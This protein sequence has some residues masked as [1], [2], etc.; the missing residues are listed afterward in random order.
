MS[1]L[2]TRRALVGGL[3]A[4]G[5][6]LTG[7]GRLDGNSPFRQAL[8]A[9]DGFTLHA[10]RLILSERSLV[11]E[12]PVSQI[13]K[14][15]PMNGTAMP[16]GGYYQRILDT[17]F[18]DWKLRVHGLVDRPLSLT[19]AELQLLPARTQVTLHQCDEGWSAVAQWTGVQLA[20]VLALSGLGK[21][22]RYVVFHCLDKLD[23]DG[24]YYYESVDLLDALHPQT[25]LAYGMNGKPLPV[26]NGA[27]LRLRVE[28]QIGYKNAKY[29]DRIEVVDS[30]KSIGKGRGGWW[31]DFD[32]AVWYAGQ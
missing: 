9:A 29:I 7:C 26:G 15:F 16:K 24:E 3:A 19:L 23:L 32:H 1:D 31:E 14:T 18:R 10:Q 4:A 21:T 2:I 22:A 27:P 12:L 17:N 5:T 30:L 11:R 25:I 6:L 8:D 28:R 20:R 13:S